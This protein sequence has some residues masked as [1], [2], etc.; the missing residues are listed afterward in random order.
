[1]SIDL[2]AASAGCPLCKLLGVEATS[3]SLDDLGAA[4]NSA[5][6]LGATVVTSGYRASE[7]GSETS[8]E[9]FCNETCN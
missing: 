8:A 9:S 6:S 7:D 3:A 1:M 4:V 5:V 2:E